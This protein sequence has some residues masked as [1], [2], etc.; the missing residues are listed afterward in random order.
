M[1][2]ARLAPRSS[3][4]A[5]SAARR[6]APLE[7]AYR[8]LAATAR[9]ELFPQL[10]EAAATARRTSTIDERVLAHR[11]L[12]RIDHPEVPKRL[13]WL[14]REMGVLGGEVSLARSELEKA[15]LDDPW[16]LIVR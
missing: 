11:R 15:V 8:D 2:L 4:W 7:A 16:A 13:V 12:V 9:Q 10:S 3:A 6:K 5:P 1:R 14:E